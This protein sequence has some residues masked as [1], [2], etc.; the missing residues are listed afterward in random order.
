MLPAG[1]VERLGPGVLRGSLGVR[2][3]GAQHERHDCRRRDP[4]DH[5]PP[6][7]PGPKAVPFHYDTVNGTLLV[8]V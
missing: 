5:N 6:L 7:H 3:W 2:N 8:I 4:S 1:N